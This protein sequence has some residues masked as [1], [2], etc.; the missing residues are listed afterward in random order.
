MGRDEV[1]RRR[2]D[3]QRLVVDWQA[4]RPQDLVADVSAVERADP[5]V[6]AGSGLELCRRLGQTSSSYSSQIDFSGVIES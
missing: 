6:V 4:D 1:L 5:W 2:L 3:G